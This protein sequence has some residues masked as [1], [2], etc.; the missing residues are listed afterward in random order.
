MYTTFDARSWFRTGEHIADGIVK[1]A[2]ATNPAVADLLQHVMY[3]RHG[4]ANA[5]Y[6]C[7][8]DRVAALEWL[9]Y[10]RPDVLAQLRSSGAKDPK[11]A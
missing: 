1:H 3:V 2:A 9:A 8:V 11:V 10:K 6:T 4:G 5:G 7:L